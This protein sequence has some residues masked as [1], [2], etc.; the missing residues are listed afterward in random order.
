MALFAVG[1]MIGGLASGWAADHFG[2]KGAMLAN[3]FVA[4]LAA[5]S[6]S[7]A[8]YVKVYH[9]IMIGR[10]IIGINAGLQIVSSAFHLMS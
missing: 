9:L 2:R 5:V 10:V 6:M 8:R 4:V 1:G 3:N 7:I